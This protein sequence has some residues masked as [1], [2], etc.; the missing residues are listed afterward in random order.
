MEVLSYRENFQKKT[1]R[2]KK[3]CTRY[4][5]SPVQGS[6]NNYRSIFLPFANHYAS[7]AVDFAARIGGID[8]E[9]LSYLCELIRDGSVFCP[10]NFW[11][12]SLY[13]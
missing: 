7:D 12:I 4:R 10:G 5:R 8:D 3:G 11:F 6:E 2:S 1:Q 13:F 9:E